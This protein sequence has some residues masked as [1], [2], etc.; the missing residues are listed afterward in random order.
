MIPIVARLVILPDETIAARGRLTVGQASVRRCWVSV[1]ALFHTG[2]QMPIATPGNLTVGRTRVVIVWVTVIARFVSQVQLSIAAEG[3]WRPQFAARRACHTVDFAI[4]AGVA[5]G[6]LVTCLIANAPW[7]KID[8]AYAIAAS[9]Q[10]AIVAASIGFD[11]IAIIAQLT[12]QMNASIA[13]ARSPTHKRAISLVAVVQ[14]LITFFG[15]EDEA[16][17]T[18]RSAQLCGA[19]CQAAF[20]ASFDF[21]YLVAPVTVLEVSVV[22]LFEALSHAIATD[23][24]AIKRGD[25]VTLPSR[26]HAAKRVAA[27][28]SALIAIVTGFVAFVSPAITAFGSHTL[29]GTVLAGTVSG[30]LIA[31]FEPG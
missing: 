20:V 2:P 29:F 24:R 30:A 22:A 19:G 27:V 17:S 3:S 8:A 1:V 10:R 16:I 26:L 7:W 13:T 23:G 15:P 11:G 9:R 18:D 14:P 6:P 4:S 28:P 21:A 12:P 25:A 5:H 31:F